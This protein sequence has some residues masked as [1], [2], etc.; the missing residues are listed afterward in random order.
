MSL[1]LF[2][3]F[4]RTKPPETVTGPQQIINEMQLRSYLL[5]E[6]MQ[7]VD[8]AQV[9]QHGPK[10]Q[11]FIILNRES[12]AVEYSP[13]VDDFEWK[14][15]Q[16]V[17]DQEAHWRHVMAHMAWTRH[18]LERRVGRHPSR[19]GM[20]AAWK[21]LRRIKE[22]GFEHDHTL[23][24]EGQWFENPFDHQEA[25][26]SEDGRKPASLGVFATEVSTGVPAGWSATARIQNIA[27]LTNPAWRPNVT[28]YDAEKPFAGHLSNPSTAQDRDGPTIV[29]D[30]GA[31]AFASGNPYKP[32]DGASSVE[33]FSLLNAFDDMVSKMSFEAP[34]DL[35][36]YS[37]VTRI[38][39]QKILCSRSGMNLYKRALRSSNDSF[40]VSKQ[41][42]AYGSPMNSG[43]PLKYLQMLDTAVM[44]PA[45]ATPTDQRLT[46]GSADVLD[47]TAPTANGT[48][49]GANTICRGPRF[50]FWNMAYAF[51]IINGTNWKLYLDLIVPDNNPNKRIQPVDTWWS[52]WCRSRRHA[53]GVLVPFPSK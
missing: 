15:P 19:E 1:S 37:E 34:D 25:M 32:V 42:P 49:S 38:R 24:L 47:A 17:V 16:N 50:I 44:Y 48:E 8:V 46:A 5:N 21:D 51:P 18:E 36:Q 39:K 4:M 7:G 13:A 3:D 22:S 10:V 6:L 14:N 45:L 43:I 28:F 20:S 2:S 31:T 30:T 26:T 29:A 53:F 9:V 35:R 12:S 41:D 23:K 52:P 27:P 33:V 40:V 11:D